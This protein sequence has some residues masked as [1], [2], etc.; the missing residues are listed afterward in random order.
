MES[1]SNFQAETQAEIF[2]IESGPSL[3]HVG[4]AVVRGG[5]GA[6]HQHGGEA[7]SQQ[8]GGLPGRGGE[9]L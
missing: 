4:V 7:T 5:E 6:A 1:Q 2:P 8:A 9:A 3:R